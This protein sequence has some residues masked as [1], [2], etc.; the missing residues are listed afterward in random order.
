M[1]FDEMDNDYVIQ[2]NPTSIST[3]SVS[4]YNAFRN[5]DWHRYLIGIDNN[6]A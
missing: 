1:I 5:M 3:V 6:K 2:H 4:H